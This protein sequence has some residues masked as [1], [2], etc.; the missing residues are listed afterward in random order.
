VLARVLVTIQVA[1]VSIF[2]VVVAVLTAIAYRSD[3][4]AERSGSPNEWAGLGE[5]VGGVLI[6]VCI[7]VIALIGFPLLRLRAGHCAARIALIIGE[8]VIALPLIA[9]FGALAGQGLSLAGLVL[10]CVDVLPLIVIVLLCNAQSRSWSARTAT[11]ALAQ[12]RA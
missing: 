2:A 9:A 3:R 4:A 12:A 7:A 5:L 10:T 11:A 6:A 1:L 8:A